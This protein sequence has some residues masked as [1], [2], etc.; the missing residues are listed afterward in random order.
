MK[1][2]FSLIMTAVILL[3]GLLPLGVNA[4]TTCKCDEVPIVYIRGRA[5]IVAD[6]TKKQSASNPALPTV[7]STELENYIKKLIPV[8]SFCAVTQNFDP[9]A[10][11]LAKI[12]AEEYKDYALDKN[13]NVDNNSGISLE[14]QWSADKL[15]DVHKASSK[16]ETAKQAST[17]LYKYYF[18]YDCRIDTFEVADELHDYITAV[19]NV[20]GHSTVK[21]VAR[22]FG[23]NVL[24]AYLSRYGWSDI[25]DVI[26]YNPIM[27]GTDKLDCIFTGN[28]E[29]TRDSIDYIANNYEPDTDM[30]RNLKLAAEI[31]NT[32]GGFDLTTETA[33]YVV[34]YCIPEILVETYATCPGYWSMLSADAYEEAKDFIFG[35]Y[36]NTYDAIIEKTD[37]Y[38]ENVRLKLDE[39]YSQMAA[40]GVDVHVIAKYGTQILPIMKDPFEQSDDTVNVSTQAPGT[41]CPKLGYT[42]GDAYIETAVAAGVDKYISPDRQVDASGA[43]FR[44]TTWY[45]KNLVHDKFPVVLDDLIYKIF[46][47]DGTYTIDT[48]KKYPQYLLFETDGTN[49]TLTP[50]TGVNPEDTANDNA[51]DI[52]VFIQKIQ[53][54]IIKFILNYFNGFVLK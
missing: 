27:Y 49:E 24:S 54:V 50:V 17:E 53:A 46:R 16:V 8:Y 21:I 18:I 3:V 28:I 19:K 6:K 40:D 15:K 38:H 2:V 42:F 51:K 1:K 33:S 36:G 37:Y 25:E 7:S 39:I 44:D 45:V 4:A 26:L 5:D 47:Y 31:L 14:K 30:D 43:M 48:D 10:E 13:G 20:T 22:C 52:F 29:L 11:E 12:F 32:V 35:Y 23:S 9:F 34:N 41:V